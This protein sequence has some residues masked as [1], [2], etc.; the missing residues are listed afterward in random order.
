MPFDPHNICEVGWDQKLPYPH[1]TLKK[2]RLREVKLPV[3]F[4]S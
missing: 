1:F 4:I 2:L 3:Q